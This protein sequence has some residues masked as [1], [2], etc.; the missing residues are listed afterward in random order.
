MAARDLLGEERAQHGRGVP[1]IW[2]SAYSSVGI[3]VAM[4]SVMRCDL[5]DKNNSI[6]KI[7]KA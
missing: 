1:E 2:A 3:Q 7:E 4:A 5:R 6:R